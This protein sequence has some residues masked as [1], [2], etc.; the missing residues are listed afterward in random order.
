MHIYTHL[1]P[2]S[3]LY[4]LFWPC[5]WITLTTHIHIQSCAHRETHTHTKT[6]T[7][8]HCPRVTFTSSPLSGVNA[9]FSHMNYVLVKT[10]IVAL[11]GSTCQDLQSSRTCQDCL[12]CT[13]A[14][15]A[16]LC[17]LSC[18]PWADSLSD[19]TVIESVIDVHCFSLS[20]SRSDIDE[21]NSGDNLCQRNANCI[22]IPGSYR[23]E[24][25]P[26]FKLS[27]SGACVGESSLSD[28]PCSGFP[29]LKITGR[30]TDRVIVLVMQGKCNTVASF[31][32]GLSLKFRFYWTVGKLLRC[33]TPASDKI[34]VYEWTSYKVE[35]LQ[36][37]HNISAE[38]ISLLLIILIIK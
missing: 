19:Q 5:Y 16:P 8:P 2:P 32:E 35:F 6:V 37:V 12:N 34:L 25:S 7:P 9:A 14:K 11:N 13:G 22:N 31:V 28:R 4:C 33:F 36:Y 27:P 24:C 23:C 10:S 3:L 18:C 26:G 30:W 20:S 17:F 29:S 15:M 21:C 38:I 1:L